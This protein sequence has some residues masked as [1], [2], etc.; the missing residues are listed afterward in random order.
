MNPVV[1]CEVEALGGDGGA[2]DWGSPAF[3]SVPPQ[4]SSWSHETDGSHVGP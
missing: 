1:E 2:G 4:P 3:S